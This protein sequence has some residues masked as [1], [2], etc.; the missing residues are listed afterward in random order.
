[1]RKLLVGFVV[2]IAIIYT[3]FYVVGPILLVGNPLPLYTIKNEDNR[4]YKVEISIVDSK[5][6]K[7]L[8][9][10]DYYLKPYETVSY[11]R[12]FGWYPSVTWYPITWPEGCYEFRISLNGKVVK[13][14]T[15]CVYPYKTVQIYI[16]NSSVGVAC[17]VA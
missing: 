13:S 8:L 12:T 14:Y 3:F 10:K 4:S 6:N 15:T 2:T 1:M 17:M 9:K 7:T 11:E 5:S 16:H